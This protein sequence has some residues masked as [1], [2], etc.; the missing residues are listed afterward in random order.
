MSFTFFCPSDCQQIK[1]GPQVVTHATGSEELIWDDVVV[2]P[3]LLI[4]ADIDNIEDWQVWTTAAADVSSGFGTLTNLEGY[5]RIVGDAVECVI[6]FTSGTVNATTSSIT[7]PEGF[8]VKDGLTTGYLSIGHNANANAV[9]DQYHIIAR[10]G[11]TVV[12][13]VRTGG[14]P[15]APQPT[16]AVFNN[17]EYNGIFFTCPINERTAKSTNVL[18]ANES[19]APIRYTSDSGQ[20]I[21][22]SST[23]IVNFEDVDYDDDGLVTTGGSWAWTAPRAGVVKVSSSI[24]Y[25]AFSSNNQLDLYMFVNGVFYSILET[26]TGKDVDTDNAIIQLAGTDSVKVNK[27][28][29]IDIRTFNGD[30]AARTLLNNAFGTYVNIIYEDVKP[31]TATPLNGLAAD[32]TVT[33]TGYTSNRAV[34]VFYQASDGQ[35]RARLNIEG[36]FAVATASTSVTISGLTFLS[37]NIQVLA[38]MHNSGFYNNAFVLGGNGVVNLSC[39]TSTTGYRFSGEVILDG[40]PTFL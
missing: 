22:G 10:S 28:D 15:Y 18:V 23:A 11:D 4:T 30:G 40:K 21:P 38:A 5:Y 2:S 33:G 1:I 13:P 34:G 8:T 36:T 35:W 20:S 19:N 26:K 31:A 16:S 29:T 25:N 3:N 39:G 24:R 17:N 32:L 6:G 27:G 37:S 12:H 14:G 7:L 9:S